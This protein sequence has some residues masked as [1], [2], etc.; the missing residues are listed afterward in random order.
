MVCVCLFLKSFIVS[1]VSGSGGHFSDATTALVQTQRAKLAPLFH[2]WSAGLS[3][4]E[5]RVVEPE[6]KS[7]GV[8]EPAAAQQSEPAQTSLLP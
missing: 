6:R 2:H 4:L 8:K 5:F 3:K 7:Q 1:C